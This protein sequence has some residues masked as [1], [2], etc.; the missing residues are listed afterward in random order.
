[1]NIRT[2]LKIEE[3]YVLQ[4]CLIVE[5]FQDQHSQASITWFDINYWKAIECFL[6]PLLKQCLSHLKEKDIIVNFF[7]TT[8]YDFDDVSIQLKYELKQRS[9]LYN[10]VVKP[11]FEHKLWETVKNEDD[12]EYHNYGGLFEPINILDYI[13]FINIKKIEAVQREVKEEIDLKCK[14]TSSYFQ[15]E[16]DS[17]SSLSSFKSSLPHM[18]YRKKKQ[19]SSLQVKN[20][21]NFSS[22]EENK[23][24]KTDQLLS[25]PSNH[26]SKRDVQEK[27]SQN[28]KTENSSGLLNTM[29]STTE[30]L[31]PL[32]KNEYLQTDTCLK[33]KVKRLNKTRKVTQNN[34][35]KCFSK[36]VVNSKLSKTN[37]EKDSY[38]KD[39]HL[40]TDL[41]ETSRNTSIK[42]TNI[43]YN[44]SLKENLNLNF[45]YLKRKLQS[46][47]QFEDDQDFKKCDD[48]N[49]FREKNGGNKR[50]K[51][52]RR[53]KNFSLERPLPVNETTNEIL[54]KMDNIGEDSDDTSTEENSDN[55]TS[56]QELSDDQLAKLTKLFNDIVSRKTPIKDKESCSYIS[57][58]PLN[59][60]SNNNS[61]LIFEEKPVEKCEWLGKVKKSYLKDI[62]KRNWSK[63]KGIACGKVYS[64][65][66]RDYVRG[67]RAKIDL[68]YQVHLY[69]F[70]EKQIDYIMD[71]LIPEFYKGNY[72]DMDYILK[73]LL[74]EMLI[75]VH[76]EL[77]GTTHKES[78]KLMSEAAF[79][80]CKS[81]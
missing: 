72:E 64:R 77:N 48:L 19:S 62:V 69:Q 39:L 68:T 20:E 15:N 60:S 13:L 9:K 1:M 11:E 73:V 23:K 36:S 46:N 63:L 33:P 50:F 65:R 32:S 74:P 34:L 38:I 80:V 56:E 22:C 26:H 53:R 29:C 35:N 27:L 45:A 17:T 70:T 18:K 67:G 8:P 3:N 7:G 55:V 31:S 16:Q 81:K 2:F 54:N 52:S 37:K 47:D 4:C 66:H 57:D 79:K 41:N 10:S 61:K 14:E 21:L 42:N 30:T 12:K 71:L 6:K 25:S 40:S 76:M 28:S 49:D 59:D 5:P 58:V 51:K 78:D 75:I 44:D 43:E 24:L